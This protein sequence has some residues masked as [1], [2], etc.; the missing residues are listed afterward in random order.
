MKNIKLIILAF[1]TVFVAT[2]CNEDIDPSGERGLPVASIKNIT[3]AIYL[4][5]DLENTYVEFD[6][7]LAEGL[8]ADSGE[9][10][11]SINGEA[12]QVT[13]QSIDTFPTTLH[14]PLTDVV[15]VLGMD[16]SDIEGGE[17]INIEVLTIVNGKKYRSTANL[18]PLIACDYVIEEVVGTYTCSSAGWG[19]SGIITITADEEDPFTLYV[20]GLAEMDG[21]DEDQGPLV[22]YVNSADYSVDAP[23]T[24]LASEAFGY[25]NYTY[26]GYGQFNT[27]T[28][29]FSMNMSISVDQ[30]SFG[31]YNDFVFVKQQ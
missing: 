4:K 10:Q 24:V 11:V 29:E 3:Q 20:T 16:L 5:T 28:N 14:L 25:T 27:C 6:V 9:V 31:S 12:Q 17:I 19:S 7:D 26:E 13:L 21:V 2:S 8:T 30:G 18:N 23:A 22:M 1:C 15:E